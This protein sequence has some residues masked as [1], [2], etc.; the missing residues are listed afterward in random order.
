[1]IRRMRTAPW[2]RYGACALALLG[3]VGCSRQARVVVYCAQDKEFA[4]LPKDAPSR[5]AE[6]KYAEA[7]PE[8]RLTSNIV[9][10]VHRTGNKQDQP[11]NASKLIEED[12][13]PQLRKIAEDESGNLGDTSTLADPTVVDDLVSNRQNRKTA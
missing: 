9:L 11:G 1:M 7:F 5:R 10:V 6:A 2:L 4:F 13:Y 3:A 8:D 12:L